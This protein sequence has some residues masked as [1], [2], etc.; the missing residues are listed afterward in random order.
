VAAAAALSRTYV[1][2]MPKFTAMHVLPLLDTQVAA[3]VALTSSA[4]IANSV[5]VNVLGFD[6]KFA[7]AQQIAAIANQAA[8]IDLS[9]VRAI[10]DQARAFDSAA[11]RADRI[12]EAVARRATYV[13]PP[14]LD[15]NGLLVDAA[16][17]S[18]WVSDLVTQ[19]LTVTGLSERDLKEEA[20]AAYVYLLVAAVVFAMLLNLPL[21][22]ALGGMLGFAAHPPAKVAFK[23][24]RS[25]YGVD[26]FEERL[27]ES[28]TTAPK[29][30]RRR[31]RRR[32]LTNGY[33][34]VP[35]NRPP[36]GPAS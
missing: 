10:V 8:L 29:S 2:I 23:L 18:R 1:E 30:P 7:S 31:A 21:F 11:L 20:V 14:T 4:A 35:K 26:W 27:L 3:K 13:T 12:I 32:D 34:T 22:A 15:A 5:T 28:D 9:G 16:T 17:A 36:T 24:S 25:A 19:V 6:T 33:R